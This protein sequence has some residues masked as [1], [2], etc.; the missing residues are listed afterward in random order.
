[1]A[2]SERALRFTAGL[3]LAVAAVIHLLPLP[4]V[5]GTQMLQ[6]LYGI[7]ALDADLLLLLRHR[8]LLFGLLGMLLLGAIRHHALRTAAIGG[9][10][11]STAGFLL[12]AA[13]GEAPG[14]AL[15]PVLVADI[16]ALLCL[17]VAATIH[18][19]DRTRRQTAPT[20]TP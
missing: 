9:G 3:A 14:P 19:R 12:L 20:P 6:R 5:L 13:L 10:V 17:L 7:E 1:M 11:A 16:V 15:K 4:G 8:A 2:S 18:I